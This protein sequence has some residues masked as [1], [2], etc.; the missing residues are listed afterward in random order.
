MGL[1]SGVAGG[2]ENG[3]AMTGIGG[4]NATQLGGLDPA[5][6]RSRAMGQI[7]MAKESFS[8]FLQ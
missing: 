8:A 2:G 7:A 3:S 4:L 6:G 5:A 1:L